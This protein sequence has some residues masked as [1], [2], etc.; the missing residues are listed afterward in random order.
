MAPGAKKTVVCAL[1]GAPVSLPQLPPI[2]HETRVEC[3]IC[4]TALLINGLGRVVEEAKARGRGAAPANRPRMP[5]PPPPPPD[6][7]DEP[8]VEGNTTEP[9][10]P[11]V[12]QCEDV[13]APGTGWPVD[14]GPDTSRI[15][16][17]RTPL[18]PPPPAD[19]LEPEH[20]QSSPRMPPTSP[21]PTNPQSVDA[22]EVLVNTGAKGLAP[23]GTMLVNVSELAAATPAVPPT[24]AEPPA[25]P[26]SPAPSATSRQTL[27]RPYLSKALAAW[28]RP[29]VRLAIVAAGLVL[30]V[31]AAVL[32]LAGGDS[33]TEAVTSPPVAD[34]PSAV[35]QALAPAAET[36][37]AASHDSSR[38]DTGVEPRTRQRS[39]APGGVEAK[40]KT[41]GK[42]KRPRK[43]KA[44]DP[45]SL[46][47]A[48]LSQ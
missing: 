31:V 35:D 45:K 33:E 13:A 7:F 9:S 11:D 47:D 16:V 20:R 26:A 21:A 27:W 3:A 37:S 8:W 41:G 42:P 46:F 28:A 23:T 32:T 44:D 43:A 12:A 5:S 1:C 4:N 17:R 2:G 34:A 10:I 48:A 29:R 15:P 18:P 25:L 14:E 36:P 40:V 39:V 30:I 24:P 19:A 6:A 38:T 22:F